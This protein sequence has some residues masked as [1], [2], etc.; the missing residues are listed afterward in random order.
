MFPS[1]D[2]LYGPLGFPVLK[3]TDK[4][5]PSAD[6]DTLN[7]LWLSH[8]NTP[9]QRQFLKHLLACRLYQQGVDALK[10]YKLYGL[11]A[12]HKNYIRLHPSMNQTGTQTT[13][14]SSSNP[15]GQNISKVETREIAGEE[16]PG[17][18]LREIFCP[19]PGKIWYAIDYSQLQLRIFAYASGEQSLIE[20]LEA[21]YDYL[22]S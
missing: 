2:L 9:S 12:E 4:G 3:K 7:D 5:N 21:G 16:V 1:H 18:K 10:G 19:L 15:N 14:F 20:A 8:A 6:K 11:P 13:R 17:P 22:G